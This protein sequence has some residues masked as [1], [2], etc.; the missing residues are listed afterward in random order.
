MRNGIQGYQY[1]LYHHLYRVTN[2]ICT[3]F[4]TGLPILFVPPSLQ[5]YQYY[6]YHLL[7]RVT[8][9]ICTTF[10]TGL[11]ILFIPPSLQGYRYY[12]TIS[13]HNRTLSISFSI[14][15]PAIN[16]ISLTCILKLVYFND[17]MKEMKALSKCI[18]RLL[19]K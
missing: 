12:Y 3:T 1:Y 17:E 14:T 10:S 6:L 4:S 5:G 2:I 13:D 8:N 16:V 19:A 18:A 7:Y 9:I 15:A 11:P